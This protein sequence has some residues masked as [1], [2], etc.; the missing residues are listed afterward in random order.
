M[1]LNELTQYLEHPETLS[2]TTLPEIEQ[3]KSRFPYSAP[4]LFLYLYNLA[5]VRDVRYTAE[6]QRWA[7]YLPDRALLYGMAEKEMPLPMRTRSEECD[8]EDAFAYIDRFLEAQPSG[9]TTEE[10][11]LSPNTVHT[12]YLAMA[13]L[14]EEEGAS[15]HP[16]TES[17]QIEQIVPQEGD[18]ALQDE[19]L[20]T[21]TLAK[22]YVSQGR[23]DKALSVYK[24]LN[25]KHPEKSVYFADQIRFIERLVENNENNE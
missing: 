4:L 13:G 20:F 25:A 19:P 7:L 6:L 1:T 10:T 3:L 17:I 5:V 21:E 8:D 2:A 22:I 15:L 14:S 16:E 9:Q 18:D 23:Y 11:A 24:S 12:D